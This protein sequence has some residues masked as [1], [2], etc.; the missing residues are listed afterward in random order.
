MDIVSDVNIMSPDP[1]KSGNNVMQI[2]NLEGGGTSGGLREGMDIQNGP[3]F[4]SI[5]G[6]MNQQS[7]TLERRRKALIIQKE[8]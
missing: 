3:A 1:Y 4:K 8:Q 5:G 6:T 7:K 2:Y